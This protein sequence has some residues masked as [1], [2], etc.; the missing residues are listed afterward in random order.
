MPVDDVEDDEVTMPV[1]EEEEDGQAKLST[2]TTRWTRR[3]RAGTGRLAHVKEEFGDKRALIW[4]YV[5]MTFGGL[6]LCYRAPVCVLVLL[7]VLI[8]LILILILILILTD[9]NTDTDIGLE[10]HG[11]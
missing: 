10:A 5:A 7:L 9:T 2:Q 4:L 1:D 3:G 6:Q 8:L 11:F